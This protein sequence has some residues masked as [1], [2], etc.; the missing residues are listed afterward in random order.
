MDMIER[1]IRYS[2]EDLPFVFVA[3]AVAFSVHEFAHAYS[4]YKLGDPTAK[5]EGRVTLNPRKHLDIIGTLLIFIVGFG[6]AKPVPV[7]RSNFSRP[8]LMSIIVSA[9]G[10]ISNLAL[11]F[12]CFIIYA[13]LLRFGFDPGANGLSLAVNKLLVLSIELNAILFV[14]NLI[15]L[16]PLDG[17]RIVED[18]LPVR[19]RVRLQQHVQWGTIIF[20]LIVFI[21]P[22]RDVTIR[23]LFG[24]AYNYIIPGIASLVL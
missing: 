18:V 12:V 16:P 6:W 4:A 2:L 19:Y 7:N 3:L 5:H 10:P 13:V 1:F 9:A 17:Y 14:F 21:P 15:P 20:L 11:V 22:L 8:R 24:L 23:P